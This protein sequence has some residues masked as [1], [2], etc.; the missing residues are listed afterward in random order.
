MLKCTKY[1]PKS[2]K[3]TPKCTTNASTCSKHT[4]RCIKNTPNAM[5]LLQH[6]PKSIKIH[7]QK[8]SAQDKVILN[9]W[10]F[11]II[12]ITNIIIIIIIKIPRRTS[13]PG[14]CHVP[15]CV[16]RVGCSTALKKILDFRKRLWSLA[17][18]RTVKL[19]L[20]LLSLYYYYYYYIICIIIITV[21]IVIIAI[22]TITISDRPALHMDFEFL[23][24]KSRRLG[25]SSLGTYGSPY[26]SY[27][28]TVLVPL[29]A[30]AWAPNSQ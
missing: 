12:I 18:F 10:L 8:L 29:V 11:I 13:V 14:G 27:E 19:L 3:N 4:Q 25:R 1:V 28:F 24:W 6:P 22:I 30:E 7:R 2:N 16:S 26:I 23:L 9:G 20:S 5:K 15:A 21:V 17:L